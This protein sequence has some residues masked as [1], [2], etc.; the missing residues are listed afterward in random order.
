MNAESIEFIELRSCYSSFHQ[1]IR[2]LKPPLK[3]LG[4]K[5]SITFFP[6]AFLRKLTMTNCKLY[7]NTVCFGDELQV[8]S[9]VLKCATHLYQKNDL[10][11]AYSSYNKL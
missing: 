8:M 4:K 10:V 3:T 2:K 6:N 9:F 1:K 7:S 5:C 11:F